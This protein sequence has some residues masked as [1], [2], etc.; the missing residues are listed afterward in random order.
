MAERID[1]TGFGG[2]RL[3]QDTEQFCYGVDAVLLATFAARNRHHRMVD[4]GTNNGVIPLLLSHL[5]GAERICGVELRKEA[6]K[7]AVRNVKLNGLEDRVEMINS[8]VLDVHRHLE[9]GSFDA[10][11]CNPPYAARGTAVLNGTDALTT[12]RHEITATLEDFVA[13]AAKLLKDQGRFYLVHRPSR[14]IDI[15]CACRKYKLEPKFLREV[16]PVKGGTPNILLLECR[17]NAGSDLRILEPLYVHED[18]GSYSPEIQRLYG[19]E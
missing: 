14:I 12:A 3:I 15:A 9:A 6:W 19:R 4:L 5:T 13:A 17:K 18:D 10:V 1:D 16:S 11:L 2:I 8:D 7:L